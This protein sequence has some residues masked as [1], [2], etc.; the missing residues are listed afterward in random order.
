MLHEI[1]LLQCFKSAE[2]KKCSKW[3]DIPA[4]EVQRRFVEMAQG[5]RGRVGR[6]YSE[7][8]EVCLRG[9]FNVVEDDAEETGLL[10]A[11]RT[12]VCEKFEL[13]RY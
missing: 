6:T 5:L 9:E 2:Y 3:T 4:M 12:E 13:I 1:G 7:I 11:F 8:V 10:D